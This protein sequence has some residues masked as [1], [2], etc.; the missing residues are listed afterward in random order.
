[1]RAGKELGKSV[2]VAKAAEVGARRL[3]ITAAASTA[4]AGAWFA[5]LAI[6]RKVHPQYLDPVSANQINRDPE[7]VMNCHMVIPTYDV[8]QMDKFFKVFEFYVEKF[9]RFRERVVV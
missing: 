2:V 5:G 3:G 7:Y 8:V 1:M 6:A 4:A 9:A